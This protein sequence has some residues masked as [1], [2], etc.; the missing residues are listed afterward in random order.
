M[1]PISIDHV[2]DMTLRSASVRLATTLLLLMPTVVG[3]QS[4]RGS[5]AS[6]D[7]Q[8][9]MARV[10][11][12]TFLITPRQVTS[13]VDSGYLVRVQPNPDLQLHEVSYPYAR[14]EVGLF[15][16]RLSEQYH[17]A[18]GEP[19]VVTSLTRPETEQPLNASD[20]S[21]HPTGMA[22]DLRMPAKSDCRRWLENV[23][24]DLERKQVIEATREKRPAHFHVAVFPQPYVHY[25]AALSDP[26]SAPL[27][28]AAT[29]AP[30]T[31][32]ATTRYKV[33][34]GD[35][36]WAIAHKHA[37]TVERLREANRLSTS[38]IRAGQVLR[39]PTT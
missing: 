28:A 20:R 31:T 2:L 26:R 9:Q 24:L 17:A 23:L 36:L 16:D 6:L 27:A 11:E 18:C 32:V 38:R 19:L 25:I 34:S 14:P 15:V 30:N 22:V 1:F 5:S 33:R 3:A 39:I 12:F 13:F 37:T 10:H 8:N 29:P 4:L 35:S 7:I 21:V